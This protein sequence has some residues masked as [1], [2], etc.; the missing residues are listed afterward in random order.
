[1]ASE[2]PVAFCYPVF[3]TETLWD[4]SVDTL[5]AWRRRGLARACVEFLI[6]HMR[7]HGKEPVWGALVSN[8]ASLALAASLGFGPVDRLAVF[9]KEKRSLLSPLPPG[10]GQG[11]G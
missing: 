6:D 10:E 3:E 9:S 7:R 4:V 2:L 1:L 8:T 5:E 11:E